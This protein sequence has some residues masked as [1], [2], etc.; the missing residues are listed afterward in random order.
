MARAFQLFNNAQLI[1][2]EATSVLK[3][4]FGYESFREN[5][6]NIITNTLNNGD[7]L[8]VMGTSSGKS[9]CYQIPALILKKPCIVISPLLS[10]IQ[11]QI[12]GL[13]SRGISAI[14]FTSAS[15]SKHEDYMNAFVYKQ[16]SFI[17]I[18]PE[19]IAGKMNWIQQLYK[20]IK[21]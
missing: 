20:H 18:T 10:L 2:D 6:L 3:T 5:Q 13:V 7:S 21:Q 1:S 14:S 8:V 17:Y 12:A 16:Y 19:G 15:N 9:L 11:D 4:Y